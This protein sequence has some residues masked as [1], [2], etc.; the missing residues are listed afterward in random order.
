MDSYLIFPWSVL[1][2]SG[3]DTN[4]NTSLLED[5]VWIVIKSNLWGWLVLHKINV[6][7]VQMTMQNI[8]F[9]MK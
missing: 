6:N 7:E 3:E 9:E 8:K 2:E 5:I 1:I 4:T